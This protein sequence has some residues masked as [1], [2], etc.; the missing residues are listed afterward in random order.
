MESQTALD[1]ETRTSSIPK[2]DAAS[3][4]AAPT[5]A[6]PDAAQV[7]LS[8]CQRRVK[9]TL[10]LLLASLLL[11]AALPALA[12]IAL[13][14][15]IEG[16]GPIL[17]RQPRVGLHGRVFEIYKFRTMDPAASDRLGVRST[18][19]RDPRLT[20]V[21]RR[22]RCWSLDELPQLVNVLRGEM[23]L[24]GP[25]PHA[26]G[27]RVDGLALAD[28]VPG[29]HA[30]HRVKPGMTGLAQVRG[31]RGTARTAADLRRRLSDDLWYARNWS[32]G[33]D[34]A[35]LARTLRVLRGR[36]AY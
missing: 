24:V 35:I 12:A 2:Y 36:R 14:I 10:D 7:T 4:Q 15:R 33:L 21:G 26:L 19:P 8:P 28:A 1:S 34:L 22:I 32:P 23:A 13:A 6:W 20:R 18:R 31:R 27:T 29:Y 16:P 17:F 9:R 11:L 25:R 5:A 3:S 30:R